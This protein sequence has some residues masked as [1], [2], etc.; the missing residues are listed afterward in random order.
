VFETR[1]FRSFI[2]INLF[3]VV[4]SCDK[5]TETDDIIEYW[6]DPT[7]ISENKEDAHTTL[8][9][10]DTHDQALK[11]NRSLSKHLNHHSPFSDL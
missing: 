11:G 8:I 10:Y 6:K 9:P 3:L 5:Q 4:F 1:T 7:I 2:L